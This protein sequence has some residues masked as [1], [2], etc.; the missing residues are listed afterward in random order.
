[1]AEQTKGQPQRLTVRLGKGKLS[2]K[3]PFIVT[4]S[5]ILSAPKA[6]GMGK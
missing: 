5:T 4:V 1:M 6:K 2:N 3:G